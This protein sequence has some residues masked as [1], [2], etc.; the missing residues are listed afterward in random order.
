MVSFVEY[1]LIQIILLKIEVFDL[2]G[3]TCTQ[4][5]NRVIIIFVLKF[6][7]HPNRKFDDK[8]K[9]ELVEQQR[10]PFGLESQ[11]THVRLNF[12]WKDPV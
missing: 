3:N 9:L 5:D 7:R 12:I 6:G 8:T 10:V 11:I 4:N 2:H 1:K